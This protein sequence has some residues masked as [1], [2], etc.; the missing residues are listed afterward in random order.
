LENQK[1]TTKDKLEILKI[2]FNT[3]SNFNRTIKYITNKYEN[4]SKE[5][6]SGFR[7]NTKK[8]PILTKI[9]SYFV[10]KKLFDKTKIKT[11]F[12]FNNFEDFIKEFNSN[13]IDDFVNI[14]NKTKEIEKRKIKIQNIFKVDLDEEN[15][16]KEIKNSKINFSETHSLS[17]KALKE[18]IPELLK[19]N[20]NY[21]T[22]SFYKNQNNKN[23]NFIEKKYLDKK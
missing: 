20:E 2:S 19:Q 22:L 3:N 16:F 5:D 1:L 18:Y 4:I 6:I 13:K 12:N 23:I 10:F 14:L 15:L 17:Y 8:E 21:S 7:F 11:K 9:N